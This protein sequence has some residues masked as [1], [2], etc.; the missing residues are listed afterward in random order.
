MAVV[1]D[2]DLIAELNAKAGIKTAPTTTPSRRE[3]YRSYRSQASID[4]EQPTGTGAVTDDALKAE[5]NDRLAA[6]QAGVD[7]DKIKD[8]RSYKAALKNSGGRTGFAGSAKEQEGTVGSSF[9]RGA[10]G[11]PVE[12]VTQALVH[13][14]NAIQKAVGAD[15]NK[16]LFGGPGMFSDAEVEYADALP[17]VT[18]RREGVA[19]KERGRTGTDVA[20]LAGSFFTPGAG[21]GK[22]A[23]TKAVTG[24]ALSGALDPVYDTSGGY[25]E[26]KAKQA[27]IGAA[28]G[29]LIGGTGSLVGR[30]G[31]RAARRNQAA[32]A[33]VEAGQ[34]QNIPLSL[35]EASH[36]GTSAIASN[37][38]SGLLP[39]A[40]LRRQFEQTVERFGS[41]VGELSQPATGRTP[42]GRTDVGGAVRAGIEKYRDDFSAQASKMYDEVNRHVTPADI[43]TP[44]KTIKALRTTAGSMSSNPALADAL[45]NSKL[46][47][48]A[49]AMTK[50]DANGNAIGIKAL[51][52]ADAHRLRKEIGKLMKSPALV[53]DIHAA[54]L[55]QVY[56][57]LTAE[58]RDGLSLNPEALRAFDSAT[59]F[60]REGSTRIKDVL[61]R[62][63][64]KTVANSDET[65]ANKVIGMPMKDAAGVAELRKTLQ[66]EEWD[67]VA[68]HIFSQLGHTPAG[69]SG[70]VGEG[71]SI[72]K[73]LTDYNK[74]R[75]NKPAFDAAFGGTR[76]E[77]MA[78]HYDD[79]ARV[80][81]SIK[82]LGR[83]A[84]TSKTAATAGN[85]GAVMS[86]FNPVM[87]PVLAKGAAGVWGLSKMLGSPAAMKTFNGLGNKFVQIARKRGVRQARKALQYRTSRFMA[88]YLADQEPETE[89]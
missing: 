55:D 26:A 29:G 3:R 73:F 9:F 15:P 83:H 60:Y 66:P 45:A 12:A 71:F 69:T 28:A 37:A 75:E 52:F 11:K 36:G 70:A 86:A 33:T 6:Q 50:F 13:G 78:S 67:D 87:W 62:I 14:G 74:L 68:S 35:P 81:D 77:Q 84:N 43:V 41:R 63:V 22:S 64:G 34:R 49:D 48:Y 2:P 20:E 40:P 32:R 59:D 79:L 4:A 61:Q 18:A 57:S 8:T 25:A 46:M 30:I 42:L 1:T 21:V 80:A 76:F 16:G 38:V 53:N 17:R 10:I 72:A 56:K 39:A 65:I 51:N 82:Q 23:V 24:G 88:R 5:L 85:V 44:Y 27:G 54:D 7:Y 89:E 19:R 31:S 47:K 58:M